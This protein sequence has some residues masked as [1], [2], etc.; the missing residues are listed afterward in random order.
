[1]P[2][3]E[4]LR[5]LLNSDELSNLDFKAGSYH[6]REAE[7]SP[8][9]PEGRGNGYFDLL[10]DVLAMSNT[11]RSESSYLV[12]G[13]RNNT[14]GNRVC[15]LPPSALLDDNDVQRVLRSWCD[16]VPKTI[17][18]THRLTNGTIQVIEIQLAEG[19]G[20]FR[21]KRQLQQDQE[22]AL[23]GSQAFIGA[24]KVYFRRGTSNTEASPEW[25]AHIR[26]WFSKSSQNW[27]AW[28]L[29]K[30]RL[31]EAVANSSLILFA[32]PLPQVPGTEATIGA[33]GN[34]DWVAAFDFDPASS[35]SGLLAAIRAR[36]IRRSLA[37]VAKGTSASINVE[38]GL[39]WYFARGLDGRPDT[40]V[41]V[42]DRPWTR[43]RNTYSKDVQ[44]QVGRLARAVA[45]RRPTVVVLWFESQTVDF[46]KS[47]IEYSA[48]LN[49]PN[50]LVISDNATLRESLTLQEFEMEF[51][52]IPLA[53]LCGA[54]DVEFAS[55]AI[56]EV[57]LHTLPTN[58]G[59]PAPIP[60]EKVSWLEQ[61]VEIFYTDLDSAPVGNDTSGRSFLIGGLLSVPD[62][63]LRKDV[64]RERTSRVY[65]RVLQDLEGRETVRINLNHAPGAGGTSVAR[66]IAWDIHGFF[67]VIVL[68]ETSN[69]EMRE[70]LER[71]NYLYSKTS[72][73]ILLIVDGSAATSRVVE[74]LF[75]L[76]KASNLP[77]VMLQVGRR[78][79]ASPERDRTF[80]LNMALSDLESAR[81]LDA[82]RQVVPDR[83]G[84]LERVHETS[85]T[86]ERSAFIYGLTA[87][88]ENFSGLDRF[89]TSRLEDLT[90]VQKSV[91]LNLAIAYEYGQRGIAA[92]A[93]SYLLGTSNRVSVSLESL[94]R[95]KTACLDLLICDAGNW[96]PIHS[97]VAQK[98]IERA[99]MP[100][101]GERE[102]WKQALSHAAVGFVELCRGR[103]ETEST[104]MLDTATRVCVYRDAQDFLG[105]DAPQGA[106]QQFSRLI[107]DIPSNEGR[108]AVLRALTDHFPDEPH[109]FGHLGRFLAYRV[110]DYSNAVSAISRGLALSPRD[111]VLL[112]M[113]G[114]ALRFQV[115]EMIEQNLDLDQVVEVSELA[116]AA[117]G[118][119]RDINPDEE[120]AF[121]SDIQ[122]RIQVLDYVARLHGSVIE[123]ARLPGAIPFVRHALTESEDLLAQLRSRRAIDQNSSR[124]EENC[125]ADLKRLQGDYTRALE[126]W[127]N[128]LTRRDLVHSGTRRQMVY[129][130][131]GRY[132]TWKEM[133]ANSVD[134]CMRLL[135]ENLEENLRS[136]SDLRLWLQATRFATQLPSLDSVIEKVS[137]WRANTNT[138]EANFYLYVLLVLRILKGT[139]IDLDVARECL[140][141]CKVLSR[142]KRN[143][144]NS[145]EWYGPGDGVQGLVHQSLLGDWDATTNFWGSAESLSRANGVIS[146]VEGP[147]SGTIQIAGLD[148][149]FV[150]AGRRQDPIT[151]GEVNRRVDFYLGFSYSGLR[152]WSVDLSR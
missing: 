143:R 19:V 21:L 147:E 145:F 63:K 62:L 75:T 64:E 71:V 32:S 151:R 146:R 124:Q 138:L 92:Q 85:S 60:E 17:L 104:S 90:P 3:D 76:L 4:K 23:L 31:E 133:P 1:M 111:H 14:G 42:A 33:L 129:T 53:E 137:Y 16:P 38:S 127:E 135:S 20:P 108:V 105:T 123:Y 44:E 43:W 24:G 27:Q 118:E 73:S 88:G 51:F 36:G 99:L 56:G 39:F 125:R 112:H 89:V 6:I 57:T 9:G 110:R 95:E 77:V 30:A 113:K 86:P 122:L 93:F 47:L 70:Q 52:Q 126:V 94:F 150:P 116:T 74:D 59:A 121:V 48:V 91:I 119:A 78:L 144:T 2:T 41:Q 66:R 102:T 58:S 81:F 13:V 69:A 54:I 50:F 8:R 100:Q 26:Q 45:P 5:E 149:F 109:F 49:E 130:F 114:M 22:H 101:G 96:R 12:M 55:R 28:L 152:A 103:G 115:G 148:A 82:Y 18:T 87:F 15:G 136:E 131:L 134:R 79:I 34:F 107:E 61:G 139:R 46:L 35:D 25:E 7:R 142:Y 128:L 67:P 72:R 97:L 120:Y 29:L 106:H 132:R 141:T 10:K 40:L 65:R 80:N 117:F 68:R 140:E 11:P 37:M 83:G 98:I 84:S